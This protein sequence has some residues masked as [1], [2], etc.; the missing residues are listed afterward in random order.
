ME[1]EPL[2]RYRLE[3]QAFLLTNLRR[4][5]TRL[6]MRGTDG[7]DELIPVSGREPL[8]RKKCRTRQSRRFSDRSVDERAQFRLLLRSHWK[9]QEQAAR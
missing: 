9:I 4:T 8:F 7:A 3:R 5:A 1:R 6:A 2:G